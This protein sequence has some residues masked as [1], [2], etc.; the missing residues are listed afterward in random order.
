MNVLK[1]VSQVYSQRIMD[2]ILSVPF[3]RKPFMVLVYYVFTNQKYSFMSFGDEERSRAIE[4]MRLLEQIRKETRIELRNGEA[5]QIFFSVLRTRK[6]D[7]DLAEV[8]V[9]CGGSAKL[10]CEAKGDSALHLFDTFNGIPGI[11]PIDA[12]YISK[13]EYA[14]SYENV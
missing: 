14:S 10:I 7:G 3:L 1:K 4:F 12:F 13:G 11:S 5:Y 9:Y 8:G 6:I 2:A